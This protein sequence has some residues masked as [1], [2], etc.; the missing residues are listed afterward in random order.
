MMYPTPNCMDSLPI[1]NEEA[2]KKQYETNRPGRENH[3]T[4]REY[5][6]YPKPSE[7]W[8]TPTRF[9]FNTAVKGRTLI[10][11]DT[12]KSNLKEAVQRWPTPTADDANN[13]SRDSGAFDSLTRSVNKWPSPVASGKLNGGTTRDFEKLHEMKENGEIS[14]EERRSMSAGNGGQ[15]NPSWVELLMGWPKNWTSLEPMP[16]DIFDSWHDSFI[17]DKAR[18]AWHNGSWETGTDRLAT[19]AKGRIERLKAI[20]NGQVPSCAA[21]AWNILQSRINNYTSV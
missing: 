4:L 11:S 10:D 16:K 12:Y 14:E 13:V 6:A 7:M 15:L 9:D 5:V 3:S 19:G 2:L 17:S 18:K 21:M 20:G 8:P 1:R